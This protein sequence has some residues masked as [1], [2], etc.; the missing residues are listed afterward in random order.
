[1]RYLLKNVTIYERTNKVGDY[2]WL[3][4]NLFFDA[5]PYA[6]PDPLP[7]YYNTSEDVVKL[8]MP[9]ATLD[10]TR[11]STEQKVYTIDDTKLKEAITK[12]EVFDITHIDHIFSVKV[13]LPGYYARVHKSDR[14]VNGQL[15]AK[16]GEFV[17]SDQGEIVPVNTITL[18]IKKRF[19]AEIQDPAQQWVWVR[20][21]EDVMRDVLA[22]NYKQ[23]NPPTP[24]VAG[25]E[26]QTAPEAP[27]E[28]PTVNPEDEIAKARAILAAAG[29]S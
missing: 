18:Y 4:A 5:D 13:P 16:K 14:I 24:G 6:N 20:E 27:A 23:Y 12:G 19:D 1:M 2:R 9:Y 11:T 10:Q 29:Q 28:A 7:V 21:P 26:A 25:V 15:V 17:K 8:W 22:R 3:F